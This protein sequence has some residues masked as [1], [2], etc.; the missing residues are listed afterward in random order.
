MLNHSDTTHAIY[1]IQSPGYWELSSLERELDRVY[2]I[3][4]GCR[5]CW[6]LCPSFPAL[7]NALDGQAEEKRQVAE[8]EGRVGAVEERTEYKDLPEG[9]H[10]ADASIEVEFVGDVTELTEEEKWRVIDLCYQ[11]KLC[12]PICPYTPDKEHEFQLDFPRLMLRAQ[13]IRTQS[14]GKKLS[15]IFLSRTDST[16]KMGTRLAPVTNWINGFWLFRF[17]MEKI[18]GISRRRILPTFHRETF[19]RWFRKHRRTVSVPASP[20]GRVVIF[21][22]CYTNANDPGVGRASVKVLEHNGVEVQIAS[23]RCCGAPHLSAGDFEAFR[24][25]ALPNIIDL[26]RWVEQGYKIVVTGPP[27]CS[28]TIRQDYT[29][30]GQGDPDISAKVASVAANTM[31]ISQYLMMLH[32]EEKLN[33]TFVNELGEINYH[34]PCHLKAQKSGFK[35]RDLLRLVPGTKVNMIDKC[36][37]MDGGWGMKAEFFDESMQMADKL[38]NTINRKPAQ[39]TCSD[40]TLAGMQIHQ[41]SK[42]DIAPIHPVSLILHAY[43]L[44]EQSDE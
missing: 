17:L 25:Q 21:P 32:K 13:A 5:L 43:G 39:H 7:F 37:G 1:D 15:D 29:Y 16:G 11:C 10:A 33:T 44:D 22:T 30:V 28:L 31:D 18:M 8:Q 20:I 36:S 24:K 4:V 42:G 3:C 2:D 26:E 14:Q 9:M 27:T 23:E 19:V 38:V 40:C 35:S 41:A 6:N 12:D 34:L